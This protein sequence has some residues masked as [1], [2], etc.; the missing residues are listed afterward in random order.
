M[1]P[2]LETGRLTL[3]ELAPEDAPEIQV[4]QNAPT[5]WRQMAVEPDE[6]SDAAAR[7]ANY[8]KYRG[9]GA[10]R[11]LF[12]YAARLKSDG[13]LVGSVSLA[14]SQPGIASLGLSVAAAH[15]G[16]GYGTELADRILAF[17]FGEISL[18]RIAADVAVENVACLRVMEKIGME[19]EGVSRDCIFAQGRWWTEA[20][21]AMLASAALTGK[22][23]W[24]E[25]ERKSDRQA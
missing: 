22:P 8:Q 25:Q 19:R 21:Y 9:T 18:H 11:R 23:G 20:R 2:G 16:R 15:G 14:R 4:W 24:S 5:Q 6:F 3:R 17:G 12:V 1:L 13:T 10:N 7:I